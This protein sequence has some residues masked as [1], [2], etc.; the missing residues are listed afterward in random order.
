MVQQGNS[1]QI[2]LVRQSDGIPIDTKYY[3]KD[4]SGM[5]IITHLNAWNNPGEGKYYN[6]REKGNG[7]ELTYTALT[8]QIG[9]L[10]LPENAILYFTVDNE[11]KF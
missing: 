1:L 8:S 10:G 6:L 7:T 11:P 5:D 9:Q 3:P 4:A 2:T